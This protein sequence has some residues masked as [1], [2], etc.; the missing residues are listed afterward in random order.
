MKILIAT[1]QVPFIRGGAEILAEGLL[2]A[3][4][5]RGYEAEIAAIPFKGYPP[6]RVLEQMLA[7]R[8]LDL[9]ESEGAPVDL[10]IGLKFP[11]YLAPHPKKVLWLLH[12]FRT[13]YELWD[14][15]YGD[16]HHFANG[17]QVRDA[18]VRV[19]QWLIPEAKAV[20][21]ISRN[22]SS[23]L[24]QYCGIDSTPLYHPPANASQFYAAVAEDYFFFPSRLTPL[25]RQALVLEALAYT[26]QPV[27][28]R[29]A[30]TAEGGR[31]EEVLD[32]RARELKVDH[33]VEKLGPVTEEEKRA[34]YAH[35]L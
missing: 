35:A 6:E 13:A 15:P 18:I 9:T 8:L 28:V 10:L 19:D 21:T 14:H 11:A 25:K 27:R 20:F 24:W 16:L 7:C 3:I 4:R 12:Q 33:R 2:S 22:V 23:R 1:A 32:A 26:K 34:L 31:Y 17:A 5:A 29:L 30:G